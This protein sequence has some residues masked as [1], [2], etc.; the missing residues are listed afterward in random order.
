MYHAFVPLPNALF[1]ALALCNILFDFGLSPID[2]LTSE[3]STQPHPPRDFSLS[4]I[5]QVFCKCLLRC[6]Q[7]LEFLAVIVEYN[8][9]GGRRLE[10]RFEVGVCEL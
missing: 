1:K 5:R 10:D 3:R 4:Q 2:L 6:P 9:A 7:L 8:L